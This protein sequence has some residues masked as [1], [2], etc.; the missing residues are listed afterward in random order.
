[1]PIPALCVYIAA[2]PRLIA[3]R[4]LLGAEVAVYPH[5]EKADARRLWRS[6]QGASG[7]TEAMRSSPAALALIGIG[8]RVVPKEGN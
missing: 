2:L 8:V 7:Q 6:W 3:E 4:Q 1:M 5:L